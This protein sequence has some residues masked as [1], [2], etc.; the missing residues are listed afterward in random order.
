MVT[1]LPRQRVVYEYIQANEP[2]EPEEMFKDLSPESYCPECGSLRDEATE[3]QYWHAIRVLYQEGI[4]SWN[5]DW[6]LVTEP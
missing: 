5:L 2:V 6:K 4:I 3:G 1:L